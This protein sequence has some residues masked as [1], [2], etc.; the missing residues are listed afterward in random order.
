ME[1]DGY[2]EQEFHGIWEPH[3]A[4]S[5]HKKQCDL[6]SL[7]VPDKGYYIIKPLWS[8]ES[9]KKAISIPRV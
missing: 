2:L 8:L 1:R 4:L 3:V 9:Y 5:Y 6:S 7:C